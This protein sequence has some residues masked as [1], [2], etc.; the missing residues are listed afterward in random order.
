MEYLKT[1]NLLNNKP[2]QPIKLRIKKWIE[3]NDESRG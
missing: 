3:I 2:N 1:I